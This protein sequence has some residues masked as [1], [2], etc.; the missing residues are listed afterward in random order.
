MKVLAIILIVI[1]AVVLLS[2]IYYA[3]VARICFHVGFERKK[4]LERAKKQATSENL[5]QFKIDLCWWDKQKVQDYMVESNDGLKLYAHY[6]EKNRSKLVVVIH[7]YGANY[8]EM[9]Q[10]CKLFVDQN[11]SVFA[12]ENR[13]HGQSEGDMIGFGVLDKDDVL[14]WLDFINKTFNNPQI[15]LFGLSMGGATVCLLAGENLPVNV[16]CIISDCGF[17]NCYRQMAYINQKIA[18]LPNFPNLWIFNH[19][20][21][22]VYNFDMKKFDAVVTCSKTKVPILFIHGVA[23]TFVPITN[24]IMMYNATPEKLRDNFFVEGVG[25]AMSYPTAGVEYEK[26]VHEFLRKNM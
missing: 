19:Y 13:A 8:K 20:L 6:I 12:V 21:K 16:K 17:S 11:Y 7:G 3:L 22:T 1:C 4:V 15:C 23:D 26:K 9:Q 24:S 14:V 25:H 10:Y 5:A 2:L 18:H